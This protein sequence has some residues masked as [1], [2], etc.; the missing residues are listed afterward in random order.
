MIVVFGFL[1]FTGHKQQ[2]KEAVGIL[3]VA[4]IVFIALPLLVFT[5]GG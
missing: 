2:D 3:A 5:T 1:I 4:A